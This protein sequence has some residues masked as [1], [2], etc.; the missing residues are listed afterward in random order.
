M[1][2]ATAGLYRVY[3]RATDANGD[4]EADEMDWYEGAFVVDNTAPAVSWS[5]PDLPAAETNA[6]AVLASVLA[7][8]R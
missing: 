7:T 8:A 1:S 2:Q 6:A 5:T 4:V 3:S